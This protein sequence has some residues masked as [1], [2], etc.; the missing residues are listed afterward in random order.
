VSIDAPSGDNVLAR[1]GTRRQGERVGGTYLIGQKEFLGALR[2]HIFP[3]IGPALLPGL[4][5]G[6]WTQT[7]T[8]G[9]FE[10]QL[11]GN[12]QWVRKLAGPPGRQRPIMQPV[13]QFW[14][15]HRIPRA[16]VPVLQ[17]WMEAN[18]R[19]QSRANKVSR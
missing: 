14:I 12:A 15:L 18:T 3:R 8:D 19:I 17:K 9:R 5:S 13:V 2:I 11:F 1:A 7:T 4:A 10:R 6:R 16:I